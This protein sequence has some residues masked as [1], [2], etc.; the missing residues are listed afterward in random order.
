MEGFGRALDWQL[1]FVDSK[2]TFN[3]F[4]AGEV[5]W[6]QWSRYRAFISLRLRRGFRIL[7]YVS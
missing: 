2:V 6:I 3:G 7:S 4:G 1:L 5:V